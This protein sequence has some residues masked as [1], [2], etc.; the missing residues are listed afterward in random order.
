MHGFFNE[1][2]NP[3]YNMYTVL[4]AMQANWISIM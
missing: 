2:K 3:E 1:K 4:Q